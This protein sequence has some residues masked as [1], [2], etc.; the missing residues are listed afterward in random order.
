M[1]HH[2]NQLMRAIWVLYVFLAASPVALPQT[3]PGHPSP[4]SIQREVDKL[5]APWDKHDTPGCALAVLKNG[6][7]LYMRGYGMA[8]LEH[9]IPNF[10]GNSVPDRVQL[11][12]VHGHV[13][14][15]ACRRR[16]AFSR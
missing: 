12:T 3:V 5:F 9:D 14:D 8:D 4:E 16:K 2:Q 6:T 11:Q 15:I 10:S 7:A 1:L 13:C